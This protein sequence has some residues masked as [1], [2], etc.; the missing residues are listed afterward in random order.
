MHIDK[1]CEIQ[2]VAISW[3]YVQPTKMFFY[4]T[5]DLI[6]AHLLA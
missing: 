3:E 4:S 1:L 2:K 6:L 5:K